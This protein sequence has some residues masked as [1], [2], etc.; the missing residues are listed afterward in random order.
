MRMRKSLDATG[1]VQA[2]VMTLRVIEIGAIEMINRF[3][4]GN[5]FH[6]Y[7]NPQGRQVHPDAQDVHGISNA[8]LEGKP[9]F[10][11]II[12]E[13]I[14]F[15]DGAKLVAHEC[16]RVGQLHLLKIVVDRRRRVE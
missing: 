14:E 3:P 1:G 16:E 11:E 5:T 12:D 8:D 10:P 13:F 7:I 6:K 4:T 15:I 2:T 9:T